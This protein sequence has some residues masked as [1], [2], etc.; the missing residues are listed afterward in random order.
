MVHWLEV[1][2]GGG[3]GGDIDH[4]HF[5]ERLKVVV[6]VVKFCNNDG[7]WRGLPFVTMM[8]T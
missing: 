3:G 1:I 6:V 5:L 8:G 7:V 2:S 4:G